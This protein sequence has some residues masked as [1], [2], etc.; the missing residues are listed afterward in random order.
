[1]EEIHANLLDRLGEAREHGWLGEVAAI[2]T[3]V[4]AA[5]QKLDAMRT[6]PARGATVHLGMPQVRHSPRQGV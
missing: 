6:L 4:A 2:E 1:L 5:Q 3:T